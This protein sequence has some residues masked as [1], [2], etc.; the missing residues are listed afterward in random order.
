MYR[1]RMESCLL[2]GAVLA[3][4][5]DRDAPT[6]PAGHPLAS[7]AAQKVPVASVT[8]T[9]TSATIFTNATLP[10]TATLKDANGNTLTGRTVTWTSSTTAVATVSGSGLLTGVAVG[11]ATITATSDGKSGTSSIKVT[12]VPVATVS[13][14][15]ATASV[16]VG[17]TLQLTATLKDAN[18]NTLTGR[19]VTWTSS[20]TSVATVSSSGL[21]TAVVVGSATITATSEG[22][23]GTAAIT[24]TVPPCGATGSGV[25][26]YV[27]AAVGSDANPGTSAQ[28]FRTLQRPADIVNPGDGVLVNDGVYTGGSAVLYISR[29]GTTA[30]WIVFR[31]AHR[32]GAIVDGQSNSSATGISIRG[33]YIRVEGF[34][35]RWTSGSGIDAYGGND[36]VATTHDVAIAQNHI[37]DIGRICTNETGARSGINAYA[38]NL[39]IEQSRIHD[40]GRLSP[41]EQ[42]CSLSPDSGYWQNH[43]HGVYHAVGDNLIMRNNVF[44]S[45]THG[46]AYHRYSGD[47]ASVSGVYIL[48][49]SFAFPNPNRVGQVV[50]AGITAG[51]VIENNIFYQP[52]TAGIWFDAS[53]GGTW[54]GA[55]VENNLS[56]NAI[57]TPIVS[58]VMLASNIQNTDPKFVSPTQ[59]DFRLQRGAR[60]STLASRSPR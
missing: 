43:D 21:V 30:N 56:T 28:P 5:S 9:P 6:A 15:P 48:N 58:G 31:A 22:K 8:V 29:S 36:T 19:T 60:L 51:L 4:C 3:G 14:S 32:W 1:L 2:L 20:A 54:V 47:G 39:V 25:C 44:Y 7:N 13:V 16:P 42:G 52:N 38:G 49:N 57:F 24:V 18:G 37:H 40:I 23:S 27:D 11:S 50:I 59:F 33:N 41:G 12:N 53:D 10:L 26:Y 55:L 46:W 17:Q 45:N 35:V 34:E